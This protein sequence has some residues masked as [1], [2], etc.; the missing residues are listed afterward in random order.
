MTD[1]MNHQ[2]DQHDQHDQQQLSG[3]TRRGVLSYVGAGGLGLLGGAAAMRLADGARDTGPGSGAAGATGTTGAT[4]ATGPTVSTTVSPFGVHQPGVTAP[5]PVANRVLAL[6]LLPGVDREGLARLMRLWTGSIAAAMEGR[7][8]PGDTARDLAQ[9]NLDL[10]VTV[11]W[12]RS[13]FDKVGL[14]DA[15]PPALAAV[16][17][18]KH[19]KLQKRWSGGDL[20]LLIAASDDTS[21]THVLRR[22]LLDAK[23]FATLR[24]EQDG[25]WR[26]LDANHQPH[27]GRNLFGQVDGTGNLATDHELFDSV[28]WTKTPDWFAGGTTIVVRR[29]S[30]DLDLWDTVTRGDQ[31]LSVG[32][33]L[34]VGA[35]LT[36]EKETDKPDFTAI[37][38]FDQPVI[39]VDSHL[40]LSHPDNNGG[41]RI[42]RRG[43]NYTTYDAASGTRD[44]GLIFVSF[45]ADIEAQ[46]T[47]IQRRLDKSDRLN[48]WTT[49]I[50]SA[51]FAVLPGFAQGGWLGDTLLA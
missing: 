13:L 14:T 35:P 31:E 27:T 3:T 17:A 28:V 39:P 42:L 50:G 16:P 23:P 36:G 47:T 40:A 24:W 49:A 20:M 22:L 33:D 44:A 19:D 32:R 12:G 15:R 4:A 45:Q 21:V 25:S 37:N 38:E 2:H 10:S 34:D 30:M 6:D 48:E 51:E 7:A 18:F 43:M 11:G 8:A 26:R 1:P 5:T 9:G 46:F 29:I 41:A